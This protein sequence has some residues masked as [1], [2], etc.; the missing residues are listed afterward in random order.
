MEPRA[1]ELER[2]AVQS[3]MSIDE[4]VSKEKEHRCREKGNWTYRHDDQWME[5]SDGLTE[6]LE[7][8]EASE[9]LEDRTSERTGQVSEEYRLGTMKDSGREPRRWIEGTESR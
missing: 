4:K 2:P 3:E 9:G 7:V 5:A 6:I 8:S 1:G